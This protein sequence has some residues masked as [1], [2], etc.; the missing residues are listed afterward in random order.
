MNPTDNMLMSRV[1]GAA[2]MGEF[3]RENYWFPAILSERL[4]ADG[5]PQ[6]VRLTGKNYVAW[7][8][9][10]G[11]VG[12]F[13][14]ACPH[15]L[16]SL[17]LARNED[18]ALRCIFHGWKY[19][20]TGETIEIPTEPFRQAELCKRVPLR[21][22]PAREAAGIVWVWLGSDAPAQFPDFEFNSLPDDHVFTVRQD[23][24]Y[25]WVQDVEGGMDAAHVSQLH[26]S[27]IAGLAEVGNAGADS[28]PVYEFEDTPGGFRY[29]AIR[30]LPDGKRYI[31]VNQ[32][33]APWFSFICPDQVPD[34]E[35]LCLISVPTDDTNAVHWMVRYSPHRPLQPSYMMPKPVPSNPDA[36]RSSW[37]PNPPGTAENI[38][39]QDREAMR[40]GSFTGFT[41][42]LVTEDFVVAES[43]G[44]I[45]DRSK[46][47][48]NQGDRAVI[49]VRR[50]LLDAVK[51]FQRGEPHAITRHENVAYPAV[52]P[53]GDVVD[54]TADWR[55]LSL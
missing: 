15:R 41:E 38:W 18:N 36:D 29:A 27:W 40:N 23:V 12:F 2:P 31:R 5:A 16:V 43:Q 48:L 35:R 7:R 28:A 14:E 34:G 32:Y 42:H 24:R 45:V 10:D 51:A 33:V 3:L 13:N 17:T 46:E 37:P 53:T 20:V 39:G 19:S 47:F 30:H 52:R 11:R 4:I 9:T 49:A 50:I 26:S 6:R 54:E 55:E 44:A 25:N 1:D 8:S 22:Y 21:H